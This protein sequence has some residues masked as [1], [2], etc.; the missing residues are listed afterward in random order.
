MSGVW[1]RARALELA[2]SSGREPVDLSLGVRVTEPPGLAF[3]ADAD[4][5]DLTRYPLSVGNARLRAASAAYLVRRF[6]VDVP[7][8]G[9]AACA[10]AKEFISTV[11]TLLRQA[12]PRV[13][14]GRDVALIPAL[15]Y[16]P[17]DFGAR[18][19][20]LRVRRV[21]V[22]ERMRVDVS[23][24]P[25]ETASRALYLWLNSPANP[26][27]HVETDTAHIVAWA[28]E[29]GVLVL[30]DEAY[31]ELT[32][33]GPPRTVLS[34]GLDGVIAVHSVSK[35]SN[36]P[37]LRVGFFA[38]DADLVGKLV[39]LRR[40]AGLIAAEPS[41][42]L[43]A[44]LLDDDCHALELRERARVAMAGLLAALD[45]HR[46]VY[47]R[48]AGGLFVWTAAPGGDGVRFADEAARRAGL[49]L[50]PGCEYGPGGHGHVRIAA[51]H[52]PDVVARRLA[53]LD[54]A[55]GASGRSGRR[56]TR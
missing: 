6:G 49:V 48:P 1:S 19:A 56:G 15:G 23:A 40:S 53:L 42:W 45:G 22:D 27:G 24:I 21:P 52:D 8:A 51:A 41:Q 29:R 3:T 5:V 33:D 14:A 30:S 12:L 38:G 55:A 32:W 28:R 54:T 35:R 7:T 4:D 37:G 2:A 46:L 31:A 26:T 36:T 10:G 44:R 17:Y 9:V 43:A 20:G 18:L 47:H 11:P 50:T 34:D 13:A 16:P 25:E 39:P